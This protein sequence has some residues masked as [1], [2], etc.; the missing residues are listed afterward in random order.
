MAR[1][2]AQVPR[3]LRDLPRQHPPRPPSRVKHGRHWRA[4]VIGDDHAPGPARGGAG[5]G[6]EAPRQRPTSSPRTRASRSGASGSTARTITASSR[7]STSPTRTTSASGPSATHDQQPR[8]YL[9]AAAATR[10]Q[11]RAGAAMTLDTTPQSEERAARQR[12]PRDPTRP[13]RQ[14]QSRRP[15]ARRSDPRGARPPAREGL[16]LPDHTGQHARGPARARRRMHRRPVGLPH[17][18]RDPSEA[19]AMSATKPGRELASPDSRRRP[20]ADALET[21]ADAAVR[22]R[23][24]L[25]ARAAGGRDSPSPRPATSAH[26]SSPTPIPR[27]HPRRGG[28]PS[29]GPSG[30]AREDSARCGR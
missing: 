8:S 24:R 25:G 9:E 6:R 19:R 23:S 20:R 12:D 17:A 14:G 22:Q 2:R 26:A 1:R 10:Q 27:P 15:P 13:R 21:A 16:P 29:R 3:G 7:S 11:L 18:R 5:K 28:S 30:R 4:P